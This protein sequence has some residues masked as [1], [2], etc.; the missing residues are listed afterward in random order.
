MTKLVRALV[1]TIV[2]LALVRVNAHAT[3]V[4]SF[5]ELSWLLKPGDTVEVLDACLNETRGM[6]AALSSSV[7]SVVIDGRRRD[8]Q[9]P[10]VARVNKEHRRPVAGLVWGASI[11]LGAGLGVAGLGCTMERS[12]CPGQPLYRGAPLSAGFAAIGVGLGA[13]IGATKHT[14]SVIYSATTACRRAR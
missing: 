3:V 13:A 2:L 10:E 14:T 7:L 6:V 1:V 5:D 8:F 4:G 11:G 9:A 12:Y